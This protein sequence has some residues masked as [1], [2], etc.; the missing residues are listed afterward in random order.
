LAVLVEPATTVLKFK[1][2]VDSATGATPFPERLTVWGLVRA[3]S[4]KVKVPVA[5]PVAV[6]EKVTPTV[7]LVPAGMPAPHVLVAIA[8]GPVAAMLVMF[9]A[10]VCWFVN[11]TVFAVLVLPTATL[12]KLTLLAESVTG[13]TPVPLRFS[14]CGLVNALSVNVRTP[15]AE[16]R[17]AGV[18]V[19]PTKQF[20]PAAMLAPHVL[21][22]TAKEPVA[23]IAVKLSATL[24]RFVTVMVL[25]ALVFATAT[26]PKFKLV[27][28]RVTGALPLPV[29]LTVWVPALSVIVTVPEAEPTTVGA[30]IT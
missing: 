16:P 21:L 4:V 19:T 3:S 8:N 9:K 14:V 24:R 18:N 10:A 13:A 27:D 6:G 12:L 17:A 22:A 1:L 23:A 11:V 15:V 20:A 2:V 28:E 7:Q 30:N 26:L 5:E 25:A 29:R